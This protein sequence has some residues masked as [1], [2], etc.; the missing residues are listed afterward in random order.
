M[1]WQFAF[2]IVFEI[3]VLPLNTYILFILYYLK[4]MVYSTGYG[5]CGIYIH[6]GIFCNRNTKRYYYI[7]IYSLRRARVGSPVWIR[8]DR[9][10]RPPPPPPPVVRATTTPAYRILGRTDTLLQGHYRRRR[11]III[12]TTYNRVRA[13]PH[14]PGSR[15]RQ[16]DYSPRRRNDNENIIYRDYF[17]HLKKTE[18]MLF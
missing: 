6:L 1:Q 4:I 3:L 11:G 12:I 8:S 5:M 14:R 13:F 9:G 18:G 17:F 7:I 10:V 2:G 16:I 15:S